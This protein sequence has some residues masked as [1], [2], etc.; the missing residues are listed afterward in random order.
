LWPTHDR[1]VA[2]ADARATFGGDIVVASEMD[3]FE[4]A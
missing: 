2:L 1:E 3:T 4:V